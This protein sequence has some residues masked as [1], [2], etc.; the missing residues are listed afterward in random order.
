MKKYL[1][2][3][4]LIFVM[5][6]LSFGAVIHTRRVH[7]AVTVAASGSASSTAID[8]ANMNRSWQPDG[9]F[10]IQVAVT[11]DGTAKFEYLI[12][13]DGTNFL[14]PSAA[15]D[16]TTGVTK[17]SGPGS[18]GKDIYSFTP[19]PCRWMKIKVTETG[20]ADSITVTVDLMFN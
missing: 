19:L 10:S 1:I 3:V 7:S 2:P 5:V 17:T 6:G 20:G 12:S 11:G 16:I 4:I 13:N 14:E 9:Y 18:D 15:S 8:F